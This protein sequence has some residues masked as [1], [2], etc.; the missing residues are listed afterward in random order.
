MKKKD[1]DKLLEELKSA[2]SIEA[3][4]KN[5]DLDLTKLTLAE[6][7]TKL[8]ADKRLVKSDI[9]KS[10]CLEEAYAYHIFAGKKNP[11]RIKVLTL[12]VA[13]KLDLQETQYLLK[14]ANVGE[15]YARNK[16]DSVIIYALNKKLNVMQTNAVLNDLSMQ[17]Y[18]G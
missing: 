18:L 3:F 12:A 6:L 5:N 10:S 15:L 14:S 8:L 7:L 2:Q 11:S 17:P 13:M 9:I 4:I 16:W 1:T